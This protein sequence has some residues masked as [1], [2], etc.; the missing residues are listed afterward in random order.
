M[1]GA[2]IMNVAIPDYEMRICTLYDYA[3]GKECAYL[4][5]GYDIRV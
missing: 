3:M 5:I 1:Q 2:A 4:P